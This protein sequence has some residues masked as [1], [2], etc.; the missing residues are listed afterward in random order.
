MGMFGSM[1][2]CGHNSFGHLKVSRL[3]NTH[4]RLKVVVVQSL[5]RDSDA[6]V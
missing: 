4:A 2:K 6:D 1:C 5:R 3:A